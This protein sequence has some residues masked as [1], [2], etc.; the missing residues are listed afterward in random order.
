MLLLQGRFEEISQQAAD[1]NVRGLIA[2][3]LIIGPKGD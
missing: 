2:C 1:K 3:G